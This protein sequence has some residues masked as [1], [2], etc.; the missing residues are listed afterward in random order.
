MRGLLKKL[1]DTSI[2]R[3]VIGAVVLVCDECHE[4]Q[5]PLPAVAS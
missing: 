3:K 5:R 4:K 1:V 2:G